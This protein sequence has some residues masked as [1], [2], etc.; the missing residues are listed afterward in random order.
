[1]YTPKDIV[2]TLLNTVD[3]PFAGTLYF[4]SFLVSSN[5]EKR[6]K[7]S[8]HV[9]LGF[10]GPLSGAKQAQQLIHN[11]TGSK[12]PN[13]WDFQI[14]N[15]PYINYN[16]I[17]E[18]G[19]ISSSYFELLTNSRIRVGNIH[20]DFRLG[21]LIRTGKLNNYFKGLNLK[22]KTYGEKKEFHFALLGG[23]DFN[24][25]AYNATLMGGIIPP[26]SSHQFEF[27]DIDNFVVDITGGVQA[28]YRGFG[29]RG[30]FT[31]K[32]K[33]FENAEDHTWGTISMY[34]R[35]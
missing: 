13:G 27:K 24:L 31:W 3:R 19:F 1:M 28:S 26:K 12:P 33:E 21:M 18:H 6:L 11:W 10:L 17:L 9:D 4:R 16:V 32:S 29:V 15:R 14:D 2:D 20:D 22:N 30:K 7:L 35:L 8:T 25:I 34:F 23:I 5:P